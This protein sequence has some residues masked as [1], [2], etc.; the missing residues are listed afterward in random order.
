MDLCP[1]LLRCVPLSFVCWVAH[2]VGFLGVLVFPT[3]YI[4][5][6]C[7]GYVGWHTV[8]V[9]SS[10]TFVLPP[11]LFRGRDSPPWDLEES[12]RS[13]KTA[14]SE[15]E[16]RQNLSLSQFIS[17]ASQ[18]VPVPRAV[19]PESKPSTCT[20][21]IR[22]ECSPMS[23]PPPPRVRQENLQR[24]VKFNTKKFPSQP[25]HT[26]KFFQSHENALAIPL[27]GRNG[28]L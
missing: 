13:V 5:Y 28:R 17:I 12:T 19:L 8:S 14:I 25:A 4:A 10:A 18:V 6:Q 27:I 3:F 20:L 15:A 7:I 21:K 24:R 9:F 26:P 23:T 11:S 1:P 2:R 16:R 22:K